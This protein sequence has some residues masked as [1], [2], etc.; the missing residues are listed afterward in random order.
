MDQGLTIAEVAERTGLTAHTLRY[1]ERAGLLDPPVRGANGHR[2]YGPRD[3][4]RIRLLSRL[5]DT[6]MPIAEVRRY[7]ALVRA[8][9]QTTPERKQ[10]MLDHR[11]QVV[12]QLTALQETLALI[13]HKIAIYTEIEKKHRAAFAADEP[14]KGNVA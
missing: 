8:G 3:L 9:D 2:R 12:E 5:R 10:L 14:N 11:A 1:Y 13:D 7:F 6:G 4:D